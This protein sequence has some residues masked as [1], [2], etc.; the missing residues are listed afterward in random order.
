MR[1]LPAMVRMP[2]CRRRFE[3]RVDGM[4]VHRAEARDGRRAVAQAF[5]EEDFRDGARVRD[6]RELLLGHERVF[7]EPVEQLLAVRADDL[8]L[9]VVRRGNR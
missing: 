7:L 5:V 9:R 3:E 1:H 2:R 8:R 4:R 6:V